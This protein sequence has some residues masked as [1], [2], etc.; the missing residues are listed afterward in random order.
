[1]KHALGLR[2]FL[3][4]LLCGCSLRPGPPESG[5]PPLHAATRSGSAPVEPP[6]S[7]ECEPLDPATRHRCTLAIGT[8]TFI[9][10][11][12]RGLWLHNRS[13]VDLEITEV[14]AGNAETDRWLEYCLFIDDASITGQLRLG[15]G[16]AGCT[17]K[18]PGQ[19]AF[20]PMR[21]NNGYRTGLLVKAGSFLLVSTNGNVAELGTSYTFTVRRNERGIVSG[22]LP[23]YD[24]RNF[25]TGA[26][27]RTTWSPWTNTSSK[28]LWTNGGM[29][30]ANANGPAGVVHRIDEACVYVLDTRGTVRYK[31]CAPTNARQGQTSFPPVAIPPGWSLAAVAEHTCA[32]GF[33]WGY[34]WFPYLWGGGGAVRATPG[35]ETKPKPR[36]I[37]AVPLAPAVWVLGDAAFN[38]ATAV[39]CHDRRAGRC[40]EHLLLKELSSTPPAC[41]ADTIAVEQCPSEGI[42][43]RCEWDPTQRELEKKKGIYYSGNPVEAL[44]AECAAVRGKLDL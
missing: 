36:E 39:R 37:T 33:G 27:Q 14:L 13:D 38:T 1:M 25:C 43:G 21:W 12:K 28:P 35:N 10:R 8:H 4:L 15:A 3:L 26:K 18:L 11:P 7:P 40:T 42:V 16:S 30:Y 5:P 22:R 24:R 20:P 19:I 9:A 23:R 2:W 44:T 31:N 17:S 41:P 6:S 32:P 34:V 29:V